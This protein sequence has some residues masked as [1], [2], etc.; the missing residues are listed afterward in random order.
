MGVDYNTKNQVTFCGVHICL[1]TGYTTVQ[2]PFNYDYKKYKTALAD[3]F[4]NY[5]PIYFERFKYVGKGF[6]L[7]F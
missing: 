5:K 6:K 1:I 4:K 7:I 3:K 2:I